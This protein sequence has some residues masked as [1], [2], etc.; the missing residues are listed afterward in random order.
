MK[1]LLLGSNGQLGY[2]AN[3]TLFCY[4]D[5]VAVDYPDIDFTKTGEVLRTIKEIKPDLI[6]NAVAYT[7]VDKAEREEELSRMIN[8]ITPTEIANYCVQNN[9]PLMHFSTDYVFDGTKNSLYLETDTPNPINVYGKTKY[10]GELGIINSGCDY[11]I[12]R[13][14]WVYSNRVGGFVNKVIRWAQNNEEIQIVDDQIGN[15]T[16]ARTL[17]I[18]SSHFVG[19]FKNDLNQFFRENRGVYH[20]GGGGYASRFEWTNSIIS[21]LPEEI[22]V[23]VKNI[24]TAKTVD[25]PTPATRPLFTALDCSKFEST[26]NVKI[27]NWENSLKLMLSQ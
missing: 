10:D 9:I 19:K 5:L 18:L 24:L 14:S 11:F 7:D 25:F 21:H 17:A 26:F 4:G 6:Y 20:L 13:T 15:P 23:K 8:A 2:E 3:R 12:F 16:W 1:I 22:L 27:P